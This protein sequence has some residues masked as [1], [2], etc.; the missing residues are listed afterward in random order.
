MI[1]CRKPGPDAVDAV[2]VHH[3]Q[4][5]NLRLLHEVAA[6]GNVHVPCPPAPWRRP[7]Q[8]EAQLE[9]RLTAYDPQWYH[10]A[11]PA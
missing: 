1:L 6:P 10:T 4:P 7:N 8:A 11:H 5:T 9:P 3:V 2:S